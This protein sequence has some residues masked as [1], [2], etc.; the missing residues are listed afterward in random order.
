MEEE[1]SDHDSL[2]IVPYYPS[3]NPPPIPP[4]IPPPRVQPFNFWFSSDPD[5]FLPVCLLNRFRRDRPLVGLQY[6]TVNIKIDFDGRLILREYCLLELIQNKLDRINHAKN[7]ELTLNHFK[8]QPLTG[9]GYL[10]S[11]ESFEKLI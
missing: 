6:H 7:M 11:K 2:Q 10:E 3:P 5:I 8:Y 1:N 4:P 9:S